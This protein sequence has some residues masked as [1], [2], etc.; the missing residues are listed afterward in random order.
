MSKPHQKTLLQ[1]SV[2]YLICLAQKTNHWIYVDNCRTKLLSA[3][4]IGV[5][6]KQTAVK[7]GDEDR[8]LFRS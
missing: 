3:Q 2:D 1:L 8:F 6:G 4:L 7:L 5:L